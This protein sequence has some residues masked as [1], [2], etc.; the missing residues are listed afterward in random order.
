MSPPRQLFGA[1]QASASCTRFALKRRLT[2][3]DAIDIAG[4][5]PLLVREHVAA[6]GLLLL[7]NQ[8]DVGEHAFLLVAF[9]EL[10]CERASEREVSVGV[11]SR[12]V[13]GGQGDRAGQLSFT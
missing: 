12:R 4:A 7:L 11:V 9:G 13:T 5:T 8:L 1:A 3:Q 2:I 6:N 10:G